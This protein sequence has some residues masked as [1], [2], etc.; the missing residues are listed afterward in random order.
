[1]ENELIIDSKEV[2]EIDSF[3]FLINFF[4]NRITTILPTIYNI[5][6]FNSF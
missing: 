2:K 6:L 3:I 4:P 1:M 5:T